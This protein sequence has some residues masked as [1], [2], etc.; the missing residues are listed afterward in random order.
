MVCGRLPGLGLG[1]GLGSFLKSSLTCI[2]LAQL[3]APRVQ[4]NRNEIKYKRN[5]N[6]K[7]H[8]NLNKVLVKVNESEIDI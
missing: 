3:H 6:L 7:K 2:Y 1:S 4:L 8:L 5:S